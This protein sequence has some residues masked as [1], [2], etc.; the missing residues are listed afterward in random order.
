APAANVDAELL[1]DTLGQREVDGILCALGLTALPQ[2]EATFERLF[3][4]LR[5]GGRFVLFDVYAAERTRQA[6]SVEL[7]ARA[8]LTRRAWRP[9]EAHCDDCERTMLPA[10]A[11]PSG[12]ALYVA[13]GTRKAAWSTLLNPSP[14]P[15]SAP[16]A[17]SSATLED[18]R[19]R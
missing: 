5:P 10:D 1:R 12:G 14:A 16:L 7:V 4:L 15:T 13:S 3:S 11:Q 9:L 6:R 19:R 18:A 8:D 2:W 17:A